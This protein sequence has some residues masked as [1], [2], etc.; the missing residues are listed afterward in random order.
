VGSA[1]IAIFLLF[2]V[3]FLV[4]TRRL[5]SSGKPS[6]SADYPPPPF[7]DAPNDHANEKQPAV[8][9]AELPFPIGLPAVQRLPNGRYNR[10]NVLNYYFSNLDL[11]NGPENPRSFCDQLFVEFEA[12]ETGAR[13]TSEYTI[14]S[15]FG[16]QDLLDQ[17]GQNL[18]FDGTVIVVP[19]WDMPQILKTV[20]DDVMERY[21]QPEPEQSHAGDSSKRY[22]G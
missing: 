3:A 9:G 13:W 5:F 22:Q 15:P 14:A 6:Y 12:P 21:V 20:L 7:P 10:P 1:K 18:A 19:R 8:I 16:L 4:V 17:T 11:Q 2:F